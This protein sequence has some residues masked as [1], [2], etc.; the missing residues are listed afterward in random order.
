[1]S[2]GGRGARLSADRCSAPC[3]GRGRG[4][5]GDRSVR[6]ALVAGVTALALVGAA[7][8]AD[9]GAAEDVLRRANDRLAG[10]EV[11][12][13]RPTHTQAIFLPD[14]PEGQVTVQLA[15]VYYQAAL[16]GE[17]EWHVPAAGSDR[18]WATASLP[19]GEEA[20]VGPEIRQ[21]IAFV[22]PGELNLVT[23]VYR[24]PT[25]RPVRFHSVTPDVDPIAAA[26]FAYAR[27]WCD[28]GTFE[29]PPHGTWYRTV[30][31][32][33]GAT[34]PPGAKAIV[35]WPVIVES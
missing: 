15:F 2:E 19:A 33:V 35:T 20:P 28:A 4:R 31:V 5:A 27:C 12:A 25:G 29:A 17:F 7:C 3:V 21:G 16:P 13:F 26:P 32:G 34:T 18:L 6:A 10:L 9:T 1:M 23:I 24:N 22:K 30:A 8:A 11:E 14:P